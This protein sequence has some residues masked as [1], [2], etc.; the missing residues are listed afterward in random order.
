MN[1]VVLIESLLIKVRVPAKSKIWFLGMLFG[2][3]LTLIAKHLMS[4]SFIWFGIK[5]ERATLSFLGVDMGY[6]RALTLFQAKS[7]YDTLLISMITSG[8]MYLCFVAC[9]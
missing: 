7:I 5:C 3:S 6:V 4:F 1:W 8:E 9:N 2:S